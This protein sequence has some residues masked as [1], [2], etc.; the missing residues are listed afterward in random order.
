M[1]CRMRD[2][3]V[4]E[5]LPNIDRSR[6]LVNVSFGLPR[7]RVRAAATGTPSLRA[8]MPMVRRGGHLELDEREAPAHN[9]M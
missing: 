9:V 8:E 7:I 2:L 5:P 1:R 3:D 4:R 6:E